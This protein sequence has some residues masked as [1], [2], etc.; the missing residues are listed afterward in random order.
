MN[1]DSSPSTVQ[2][3][4]SAIAVVSGV[5]SILSASTAS[6]M[7]GFAWFMLIVGVVVL[8]H[9]VIL[10]TSLAERLGRASGP[11]MIGYAVL[12]LANQALLA[13]RPAGSGMGNGMGTSNGMGMGSGMGQA[14]AWSPGMA[15]VAAIMLA[16]GVIMTV[17]DDGM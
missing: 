3:Y 17:R 14:M 2:L 13:T 1:D 7:G 6:R 10:L 4:G 5:F 12:M 16:S 9:G 11:L 15:A 8:A